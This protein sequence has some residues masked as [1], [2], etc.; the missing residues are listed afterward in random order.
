LSYLSEAAGSASGIEQKILSANP[1]LEAFGNAKTLRNNNSSRFGKFMNLSFDLDGVV[2]GCGT[3]NYLLEKS[4]VHKVSAGERSYHVFYQICMAYCEEMARK[5][6]SNAK[7]SYQKRRTLRDLDSPQFKDARADLTKLN[8]GRPEE[9]HFLTQSQCITIPNV[10]DAEHFHE[11]EFACIRL[12]LTRPELEDA[13]AVCGAILHLGNLQ[14]VDN[15]DGNGGCVVKSSETAK[16]A[17]ENASSLMGLPCEEISL[18]LRTK[19]L[20]V[21]GEI[22][23]VQLTSIQAAEARDALCKSMYKNCF[24]WL[25][26]RTNI[27]MIDPNAA[28]ALEMPER[29]KFRKPQMLN[30]KFIGILD[31]FGFEIFELNGFEQ[32][33]GVY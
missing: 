12:G 5:R 13:F 14:F 18:R 7:M 2:V 22:N 9:F 25:V 15:S 10:S 16:R 33:G 6:D 23:V 30:R 8:L 24:D 29:G 21:R 1:I 26:E 19:E 4:R 32:V 27:A 17:L 3:T 28:N 20:V 31:I 11:M